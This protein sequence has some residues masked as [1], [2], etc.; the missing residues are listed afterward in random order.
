MKDHKSLR[1]GFKGVSSHLW[2]ARYWLN[3]WMNV[4]CFHKECVFRSVRDSNCPLYTLLCA[5][6]C[7][8]C[9]S[10]AR[11][12][13]SPH[14]QRQSGRTRRP[15]CAAFP[16]LMALMTHAAESY[17]TTIQE[18]PHSSMCQVYFLAHNWQWL[19]WKHTC[20]NLLVT[21]SQR[22]LHLWV[23]KFGATLRLKPRE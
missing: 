3:K 17:N 5:V 22:F 19:A 12:R 21:Q 2:F 7:R 11:L 15:T 14:S 23:H 9:V 13:A 1:F 8:E 18:T 4:M 10:K 20:S 6:F 16:L